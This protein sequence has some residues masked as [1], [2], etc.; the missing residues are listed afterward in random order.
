MS[1]MGGK[2]TLAN[3]RNLPIY[4]GKPSL[5]VGNAFIDA[6]EA[7]TIRSKFLERMPK[8]SASLLKF[9]SIHGTMLA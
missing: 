7:R 8:L 5:N 4:V 3:L 6:S 2:R 1:A 9:A